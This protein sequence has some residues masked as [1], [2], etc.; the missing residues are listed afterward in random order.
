MIELLLGVTDLFRSM[1][2]SRSVS[3]MNNAMALY[4]KLEDSLKH[5]D[6]EASASSQYKTSTD[7]ATIIFGKNKPYLLQAIQL[8]RRLW[9]THETFSD[10]FKKFFLVEEEDFDWTSIINK[11]G[12]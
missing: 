8:W 7:I 6:W 5:I 11:S 1:T 9:I 12:K 2:K 3:L 10:I 4:D